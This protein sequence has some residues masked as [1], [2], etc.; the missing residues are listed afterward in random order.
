VKLSY[1]ENYQNIHMASL[2]SV[3]LPTDIWLPSSIYLKPQKG[4]QYAIGYFRNYFKNKLETS[5]EGYYKDFVNL[6][7]FRNSLIQRNNNVTLDENCVIGTGKAYGVEFF[8][9]KSTGNYTGWISYTLSKTTRRFD[10][11]WDGLEFPSKY[12][13]RH[14][15]NVVM[16]FK[17]SEKWIFSTTFIY[18]TG[19]A[20]TLPISRYIIQGTVVNDYGKP[21]SFRM[22]PYHRLD[23]SAT[24]MLAKRKRINSSLTFAIYNVYNRMN[25]YFIYFEVFGNI[26][27]YELSVQAKQVSLF[28]IMPT[29]TWNFNF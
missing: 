5:I 14:D 19:N 8:V 22:P 23:V 10:E 9:R 6:I 11:I 17:A 25:P 21:N 2:S 13:R 4:T 29:V 15:L 3:S 18:A 1:T 7:E 12:D 20:L 26:Q 27:K 24:W 28:S 16:N